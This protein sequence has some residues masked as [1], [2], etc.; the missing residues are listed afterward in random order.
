MTCSN[1]YNNESLDLFISTSV[2]NL[3]LAAALQNFQASGATD[4]VMSWGVQA[5]YDADF[6]TFGADYSSMADTA[7]AYNLVSA[8]PITN[9]TKAALDI[10]SIDYEDKSR[11][12]VTGWYANVTYQFPQQENVGVFAEIGDTNEDDSSVGYLSGM[13]LTF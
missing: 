5:V 7:N 3:S 11:D 12:D 13:Q 4:S 8:F 9:T 2:D 10:Q 1:T 6:A